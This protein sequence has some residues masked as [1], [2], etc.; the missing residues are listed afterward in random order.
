M[1]GAKHPQRMRLAAAVL[2]DFAH[3][4][5]ATGEVNRWMKTIPWHLV[6]LL[7]V[8]RLLLQKRKGSNVRGK[9]VRITQHLR[10]LIRAL[11]LASRIATFANKI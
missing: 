9:G 10:L 7:L 4:A 2:A 11:L 5:G 8:V 1:E 6:A 3:K